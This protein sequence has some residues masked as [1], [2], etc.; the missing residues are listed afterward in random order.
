MQCDKLGLCLS[1][2]YTVHRRSDKLVN[3]CKC[4]MEFVYKVLT[5][6]A[7]SY[8]NFSCDGIVFL[9]VNI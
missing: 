4:Y 6:I 7:Q 2:K 1:L 3:N 9:V 5:D 8:R